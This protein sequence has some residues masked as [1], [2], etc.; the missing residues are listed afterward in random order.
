[1]N[2][3]E[4]AR[5]GVLRGASG[6][7]RSSRETPRECRR[8]Q[9]SEAKPQTSEH[10]RFDASRFRF[11][12]LAQCL[13]A[14]ALRGRRRLEGREENVTQSQGFEAFNPSRA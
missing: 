13:L 2:D 9:A 10:V 12:S 5:P 1:L 7:E 6:D 8:E 4:L 14:R 11:T 3:V